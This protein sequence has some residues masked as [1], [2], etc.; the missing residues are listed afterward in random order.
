LTIHEAK[1]IFNMVMQRRTPLT[2]ASAST[3]ASAGASAKSAGGGRSLFAVFNSWEMDAA[4]Q[5]K[6]GQSSSSSSS[7]SKKERGGGEIGLSSKGFVEALCAVA[8]RLCA[9]C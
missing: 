5:T 3:G 9:T 4:L 8:V 6:I 1:R 7:S 2:F